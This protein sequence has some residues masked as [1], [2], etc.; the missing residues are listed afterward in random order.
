MYPCLDRTGFRLV[1]GKKNWY[2]MDS[3]SLAKKRKREELEG[4]TVS[5]ASTSKRE[6]GPV[7]GMDIHLSLRRRSILTF[8]PASFPSIQPT[9]S[10]PFRCYRQARTD[11]NGNELEADL[12]LDP[13]QL[14]GETDTLD[15]ESVNE[16]LSDI[17]RGY[18]CE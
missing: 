18:S 14:V 2:A 9:K 8:L 3:S 1:L 11:R 7:L 16:G 5:V 6:L 12:H 4:F 17:E 15:F 13:T 10:T